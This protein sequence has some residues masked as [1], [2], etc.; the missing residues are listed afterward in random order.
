MGLLTIPTPDARLAP[1]AYIRKGVTLYRVAQITPSGIILE[2]A[3]KSNQDCYSTATTTGCG[4]QS[5]LHPRPDRPQLPPNQRSRERG[6]AAMS[7]RT[8]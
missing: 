1:N 2:D 5:Q 7:W 8:T 3:Y 6:I 4:H